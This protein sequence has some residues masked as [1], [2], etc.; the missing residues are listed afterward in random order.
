[1]YHKQHGGYLYTVSK[2]EEINSIPFDYIQMCL[3]VK[4]GYSE[5][6]LLY[7]CLLYVAAAATRIQIMILVLS[8]SP[9]LCSDTTPDHHT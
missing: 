2:I 1:M 3:S 5:A 7:S 4:F 9:S 6:F 8:P